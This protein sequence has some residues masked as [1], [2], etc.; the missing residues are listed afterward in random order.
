MEPEVGT[1]AA[2]SHVMPL[3]LGVPGTANDHLRAP[4]KCAVENRRAD[5]SSGISGVITCPLIWETS[6]RIAAASS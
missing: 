6:F 3:G 4:I 1:A 5:P 2:C